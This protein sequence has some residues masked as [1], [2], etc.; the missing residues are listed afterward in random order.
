MP[1]SPSP[2]DR[3]IAMNSRVRDI[4]AIFWSVTCALFIFAVV[5]QPMPQ[6]NTKFADIILGFLLG[7]ALSSVLS[8]YFGSSVGSVTKDITLSRMAEKSDTE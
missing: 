3:T 7:S 5:F 4:L 2:G 1:E 6:A 8:F